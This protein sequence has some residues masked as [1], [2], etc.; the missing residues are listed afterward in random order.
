MSTAAGLPTLATDCGGNRELVRDGETGR[1]WRA[2]VEQFHAL[3]IVLERFHG[4]Y[5]RIAGE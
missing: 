4:L 2:L 5:A 3:S 1:R